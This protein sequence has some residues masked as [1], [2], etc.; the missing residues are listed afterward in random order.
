MVQTHLAILLKPA[1]DAAFRRMMPRTPAVAA[2]L[3]FELSVKNL[4]IPRR[5]RIW[6]HLRSPADHFKSI[7]STKRVECCPSMRYKLSFVFLAL[8]LF[9]V[10]RPLQSQPPSTVIAVDAA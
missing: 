4:H 5:T 3:L 6:I 1:L 10:F 8:L 2:A 7:F 9:P